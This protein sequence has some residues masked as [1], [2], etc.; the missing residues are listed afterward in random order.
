V[1][2][3]LVFTENVSAQGIFLTATPPG[4]VEGEI[5]RANVRVV[6]PSDLDS[7][8]AINV[9]I[10]DNANVIPLSPKCLSF[11]SDQREFDFQV[12]MMLKK[13]A[14]KGLQSISIEL[15]MVSG[16]DFD[17]LSVL[18]LNIPI[19][20]PIFLEA[21]EVSSALV[22]SADV[23]RRNLTLRIGGEN[24]KT[25][26]LMVKVEAP[27]GIVIYP[28]E[29]PIFFT[30]KLDTLVNFELTREDET[31]ALQG[32]FLD[33]NIVDIN[34]SKLLS[35][36]IS[37][38][39]QESSWRVP[40]TDIASSSGDYINA[41]FERNRVLSDR[42]FLSA[43]IKNRHEKG[44]DEF[45]LFSIYTGQDNQVSLLNTSYTLRTG[46]HQVKLGN[47]QKQGEAALFGRGVLYDLENEKRR[48]SFGYINGATNLLQKGGGANA[49]SGNSL[50]GSY[51]VKSKAGGSVGGQYVFQQRTFFRNEFYELFGQTGKNGNQIKSR[52]T[53]A[54]AVQIR[55]P[56]PVDKFNSFS[57]ELEFRHESKRLSIFSDN[58]YSSPRFV[59]LQK[60]LTLF[61]ERVT[62]QA[63]PI[64]DIEFEGLYQK[65]EEFLSGTLADP[66]S[67]YFSPTGTLRFRINKALT[68]MTSGYRLSQSGNRIDFAQVDQTFN[69][70]GEHFR[71]QAQWYKG[72]TILNLYFD[73]GNS[74]L[75]EPD[76]F[77]SKLGFW[78]SRIIVSHKVFNFLGSFRKGSYYLYEQF[79]E[80][81]LG[82]NK[83]ILSL[84]PRVRIPLLRE[85]L[86]LIGQS[87]STINFSR[88]T[89]Q[90]S[91]L[92]ELEYK[93]A[94]RLK[95]FAGMSLVNV[96]GFKYSNWTFQSQ[97]GL[98]SRMKNDKRRNIVIQLFYDEN[99]NNAMDFDELPLVG[100]AIEINDRTLYSDESGQVQILQIPIGTYPVS[101]YDLTGR[102]F[103]DSREI[104]ISK[105]GIIQIPMTK[106]TSIFG[107][108]IMQSDKFDASVISLSGLSVVARSENGGD[109]R[110]NVDGNGR[111]RVMLPAGTYR[112]TV[113]A[114]AST[115]DLEIREDN[116]LI[117][118]DD[119]AAAEE[120][121][122]VSSRDR[123]IRIKR[124]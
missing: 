76:G 114:G 41:R 39:S 108:I 68:L 52:I 74:R 43:A 45:R 56:F 69:S 14:T 67:I 29:V 25:S 100:A 70:N 72:A 58:Y 46:H 97:L 20:R 79:Q 7:T 18:P 38:V 73:K 103:P 113:E 91:F 13:G 88:K 124:F 104:L 26:N 33:L 66:R 53:L 83:S 120:D 59:G 63:S 96:N 44:L 78:E 23:H 84:V 17:T 85:R 32:K 37:I 82:L 16:G 24:L 77:V 86:H 49:I 80:I 27:E 22:F 12:K 90:R 34:D 10:K 62:Y 93:V 6:I 118:V 30:G 95:V 105:G 3:L 47:V 19:L 28:S 94:P 40:N 71:F 51:E 123:Q 119:S 64:W 54:N 57:T 102:A 31:Q 92:T 107:R 99:G 81:D 2:C 87:Y 4:I 106:S 21:V 98:A 50:V 9:C 121:F 115:N 65:R 112:L 36:S 75:K 116:R 89:F 15:S 60:G 101:V 61:K 11:F 8:K 42:L 117:T 1:L 55:D 109:F 111:Y 5:Y 48:V 122:E 110:S 35:R